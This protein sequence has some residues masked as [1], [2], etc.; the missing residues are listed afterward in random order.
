MSAEAFDS[1]AILEQLGHRRTAGRVTEVEMFGSKM[2]RIDIPRADGT[3]TTHFFSAASVYA[4]TPCSEE[5]AR[6][7]AAH[8]QPEPVHRWELPKP[9]LPAHVR[10]ATSDEANDEV[11]DY[12]ARAEMH[13]DG[14][15]EEEDEL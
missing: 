7:V 15:D 9:T 2:G 5:A 10:G 14:D 8:N 3:F 4:M 12:L 6:G 13:D 1:W 11:D